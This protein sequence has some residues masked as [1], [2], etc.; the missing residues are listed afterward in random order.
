MQG[1]A[2]LLER[3]G[4][5]VGLHELQHSQSAVDLP[6]HTGFF[7]TNSQLSLLQIHEEKT[8]VNMNAAVVSDNRRFFVLH[9]A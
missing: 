6:A 7:R 4:W 1:T 2:T 3:N 5:V 8:G 9:E